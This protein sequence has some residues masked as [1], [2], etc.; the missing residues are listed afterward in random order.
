MIKAALTA[1][2][3][4]GD[5]VSALEQNVEPGQDLQWLVKSMESDGMPFLKMN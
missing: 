5:S 1:A 4:R 3:L 2:K